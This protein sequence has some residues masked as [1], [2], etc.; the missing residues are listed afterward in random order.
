ML[1]CRP[2]ASSGLRANLAF[3]LIAITLAACG[4]TGGGLSGRSAPGEGD[5]IGDLIR[6]QDDAP[7]G[8]K[9]ER[10]LGQPVARLEAVV[11]APALV[12]R[13]GANEFR[14]YDLGDCR[15]MAIVMPAGGTVRER[16]TMA[17]IAGVPAPP[18]ERCTAGLAP[19]VGS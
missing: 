16:T 18:F 10:F 5:P 4:T 8:P 3:A 12:R 6:R 1:R 14:R 9:A 15:A 2:I 19:R 7:P 13:E 11:G 17:S